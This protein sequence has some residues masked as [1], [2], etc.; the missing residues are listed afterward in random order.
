MP[1]QFVTTRRVEFRD[2]DAAG[3][4]H[5]SSYFTF[6]EEAE[7]ELLRH[8][9]LSVVLRD[10]EGAISW[11]RVAASCEFQRAVKFEDLVQI[12]LSVARLGRRSA[13]YAF[14]FLHDS[15]VVASGRM[16]AVCCR[17]RQDAPPRSIPIPGAFVEQLRRFAAVAGDGA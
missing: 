6:M 2:T 3:I 13:T 1:E 15:Q 9:G 14:R 4:M 5:F 11:P 16:T 12:E 10:D 7:H 8:L 17:F